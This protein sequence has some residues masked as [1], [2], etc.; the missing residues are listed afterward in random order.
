M[1]NARAPF[2]VYRF[3]PF[4]LNAA[5]GILE[6]DGE[7]VQLTPKAIDTLVFLVENSGRV[8]T[9]EELMRAVWPGVNVVES[10]LTRNVSALRKALEDGSAEGSYIETIPK[11]GY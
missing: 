4:R 5:Q 10:G 1:H 8:V 9:K 2:A 6:R 3:G 7:R 11:R